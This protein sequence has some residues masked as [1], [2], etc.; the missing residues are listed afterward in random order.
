MVSEEFFY[1]KK[2]LSDHMTAK[3]SVKKNLYQKVSE[4]S[5]R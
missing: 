3:V 2:Y 1:K 5:I 4:I